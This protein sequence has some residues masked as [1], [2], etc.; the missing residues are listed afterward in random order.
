[1]DYI[2]I[3]D[4]RIPDLVEWLNDNFSPYQNCPI[5][6]L[7]DSR[8]HA[9]IAIIETGDGSITIPSNQSVTGQS[10]RYWF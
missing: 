2:E 5:D 7:H 4:V 3:D 8:L 10:R 1:M 6:D 9:W